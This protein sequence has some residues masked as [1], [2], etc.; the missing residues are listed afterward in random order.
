MEFSEINRRASEIKEEYKKYETKVSGEP[1]N[2]VEM[3]QGLVVD[4]GELMKLITIKAGI[5]KSE[6]KNVDKDIAHELS[7]ILWSTLVIANE[8]NVDIEK[9]FLE[10]MDTLDANFKKQ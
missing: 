7:D 1:W 4:V 8:L 6:G 9:E 3:T 2:Y 10:T 5:R